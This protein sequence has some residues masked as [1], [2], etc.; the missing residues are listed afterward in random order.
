V[1][2]V[3]VVAAGFHELGHAAALR[4]G[5]GQ[6]GGIGAGFYMVYPAFYTDVSDNYRLGRWARVR[7]DLGGFYFNLVFALGVMALYFATRYEPLLLLVTVINL[8]IVRQLL[9]FVRL[10]GYWV[11]ADL[12]GVP[13]FFSL[14]TRHV[15]R[16]WPFGEKDRKAAPIPELK[17]WAKVVFGLYT[18]ITV[19]AILLLM[20]TMLRGVP[21]V[22]ATIWDS[23]GQ[24]VIVIGQQQAA[25]NLG[26][27]ALAAGHLLAL[28]LPT[29]G[30]LYS[31]TRLSRQVFGGLW[32]W[33]AGSTG[34]RAVAGLGSLAILTALWWVWAPP[35]LAVGPV[36]GQGQFEPIRREERGT[37]GDVVNSVTGRGGDMTPAEPTATAGP[38]PEHA[39]AVAV[40]S[41]EASPS[42]AVIVQG[43]PETTQTAGETPGAPTTATMAARGAPVVTGTGT[44]IASGGEVAATI[45]SRRPSLATS[46]PSAVVSPVG[47]ATRTPTPTPR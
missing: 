11:L 21:R 25:G 28:A 5:G 37:V 38:T 3:T 22:L 34:K 20:L 4:H 8:E 18:L 6:A 33:S 23:G 42:P 40:P 15:K 2:A 10:D 39:P 41:A 12:T 16:A 43:T 44:P 26:G 36:V 7:T 45:T 31:L 14:M 32:R 13:D 24:Q 17:A 1:L 46:Q 47:T 29:L 27:V 30:V 9:P 35:H 19:P